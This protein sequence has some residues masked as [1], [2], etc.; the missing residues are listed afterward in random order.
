[1]A[2]E[3]VTGNEYTA[4]NWLNLRAGLLRITGPSDLQKASQLKDLIILPLQDFIS[5]QI[6]PFQYRS[7][8]CLLCAVS[9]L[10]LLK[11]YEKILNALPPQIIKIPNA[12]CRKPRK[13][14]LEYFLLFFLHVNILPLFKNTL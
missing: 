13:Y 6:T 1:M 14:T 11:I 12:H 2:P 9:S 8:G 10:P 7:T 5:F 3:V 4:I